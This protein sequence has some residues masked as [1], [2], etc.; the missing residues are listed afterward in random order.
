MHRGDAQPGYDAAK[1]QRPEPESLGQADDQQPDGDEGNGNEH[2]RE[3]DWH[4][5]MDGLAGDGKAEHGYEVHHPDAG[6]PDRARAEQQPANSGT[7]RA[8]LRPARG[9]QTEERADD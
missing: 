9:T 2:A 3:S 7:A 4:V 6:D 8:H 1:Q 5:V